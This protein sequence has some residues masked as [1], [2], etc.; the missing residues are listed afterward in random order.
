MVLEHTQTGAIKK[1]ALAQG[2]LTLR[3]D[4]ALK[5]LA[6]ITTIDEVLRVTQED[7]IEA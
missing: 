5:V 6:G 4:G 3:M 7:I 2:M 1:H